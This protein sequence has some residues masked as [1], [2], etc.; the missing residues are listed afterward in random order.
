MGSRMTMIMLLGLF[1]FAACTAIGVLIYMN[2]DKESSTENS[3]TE[4]SSTENSSTEKPST[5][6]SSTEESVETSSKAPEVPPV[7]DSEETSSEVS[8]APRAYC[9]EDPNNMGWFIAKVEDKPGWNDQDLCY[10][11]PNDGSDYAT[12]KHSTLPCIGGGSELD[13]YREASKYGL[14]TPAGIS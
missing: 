12:T 13:C 10:T 14:R 1:T 11:Q 3:S 7:G 9:I 5:E 2:F 4:E 6:K 8:G